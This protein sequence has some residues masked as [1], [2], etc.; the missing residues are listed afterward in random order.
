MALH[1]IAVEHLIVSVVTSQL[2]YCIERRLLHGWS[3]EVHEVLSGLLEVTKKKKNLWQRRHWAALKCQ[4]RAHYTGFLLLAGNVPGGMSVK[5]SF[6]RIEDKFLHEKLE[7]WLNFTRRKVASFSKIEKPKD[8]GS[9]LQKSGQ[10]I[11]FEIFVHFSPF[12]K[13][14]SHIFVEY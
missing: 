2:L 8:R 13:W 10:D 7:L 9:L 3:I 11:G 12:G 6:L 14:W 4:L 5:P 1:E